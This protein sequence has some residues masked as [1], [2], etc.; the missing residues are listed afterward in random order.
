MRQ[1]R[2]GGS[3]QQA[4]RT[5]PSLEGLEQRRVLSHIAAGPPIGADQS[6]AGGIF[7]HNDQTFV[8]TTPQGTH[9]ELQVIGRGSLEGT[10]V[11]QN[12]ALHLLFSKTNS[13]SKIVSKVHGGTGQADLASIFHRDLFLHGATESL[14]GIGASVIKMINL[15]NFNLIPGGRV[16]VTEGIGTLGLNSVGPNTQIQLRE[17]PASVTAGTTG[18]ETVNTGASG[19]SGSSSTIVSDAFLVQSL[20]GINGEFFSAGNILNVSNPQNPGPPPAPPGIVIRINHINGNVA[21]VPNLLTDA[22]VFGYDQTTGQVVRFSLDLTK[23][24]LFQGTG[25]VDPT[26]APIQVQPPGSTAPVSVSVGRDGSRDALL[27]ATGTTITAYDATY[28]TLL[29]AFTAPPGFSIAAMGSTDILTVIGDTSPAVNQL[30]SID[31]AASLGSPTHQAV[32]LASYN[33]Q[34]GV[35]LVGGLT[36]LPGS[37][38]AYATVAATFNSLQPTVT[39]LGLLTASATQAVPNPANGGLILINRFSTDSVKA[40]QSGGS[41]TPVNPANNPAL[42]GVPVGAV[43]SNLAFNSPTASPT[44]PALFS[45]VVSLVG[46]VSL[47]HKGTV[48]LNTTD[49]ITDLSETFRPDLNGSTAL[50]VGPALI[51]V[52]GNIQSVRGLTANGLV[53][54]DTG[55]LNLLRTGRISNSYILAQPIGHVQTPGSQRTNVTLVSSTPRLFGSRGGVNLVPGLL[56]VGPLSYT[57]DIPPPTSG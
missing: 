20:A 10:T 15:M 26:F 14:S 29:G 22:K 27:V 44:N 54:N 35:G 43:D 4:R 1:S 38:R 9:V 30:Q 42:I 16:N 55:Y 40:I 13:F 49:K 5:R 46:P 24:G 51:D 39:Q 50:G 19:S 57:N 52:Q 23:A 8:Y 48:V 45:N 25:T 37:N 32:T 17:L 11:D 12:G 2:S 6:P 18:S 56:Q 47:S 41:F 28:G 3:R 31:I 36:G 33:P 21:S 7:L 34:A 53:L